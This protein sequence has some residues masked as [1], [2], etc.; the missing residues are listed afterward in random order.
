[1]NFYSSRWILA[2]QRQNRKKMI[3][4]LGLGFNLFLL[5]YFKYRDF[6]LDNINFLFSSDINFARLALPLGISF[7]T[8]QQ[9]AYLVD[10]FQGITEKKKMTDYSLFVVFFPQLIAG[11]IVHY[12]N[13]MGQFKNNENKKINLDNLK[14]GIYIFVLGLFKKV[15]LADTFSGWAT[16]GF[17][18]TDTLH[19]FQAWGTSLSY[20]FQLYFDFSGYSDMAIGIGYMFNISLPKNFNSPLQARN[21][22]DF[23]SRWHIT[24]TQFITSYVF[25]PLV[26]SFKEINFRNSMIAMFIAMSISGL[27]HGAAWTFILY[28]AIH[29]LAIIVNHSMKKRK[30]KLPKTLAWF[31]AFNFINIG[32]TLFRATS[33]SDAWKV[34]QGML[35]LTFFQLP[36]GIISNSFIK[37][38]GMTLGQHM[39][40]DDN[41]FLVMLILGFIIVLK[42]KNTMELM[43]KF[44]GSH[45]DAIITAFMFIFCI[46]GLTRV[47]EFIYFNF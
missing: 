19:F 47:S 21:I 13:V 44:K 22:V 32:F 39:T 5:G 16:E 36:K 18:H 42:Q 25:T 17:D 15:I 31:L 3:F 8:L 27:W 9:I 46:F 37:S 43:D 23:W 40:N 29:G 11:P 6:F 10:A 28:G 30:I 4:L 35:G 12:Q 45:K 33:L 2:E 1:V 20:T 7:F 14:L 24:L 34:Y 26:R 38:S 41:L